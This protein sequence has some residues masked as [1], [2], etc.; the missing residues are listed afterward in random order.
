M[1]FSQKF[2]EQLLK[3]QRAVYSIWRPVSGQVGDAPLA[4]CDYATIDEKDLVPT[5]RP[6]NG[7]VAREIYNLRYNPKQKW[8]WVRDQ[9]PDEASL[10]VS[11]DSHPVEGGAECKSNI[12]RITLNIGFICI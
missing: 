5:D 8:Y 6:W 11:W 7:I 10:F 4:F 3:K 1:S 9:V 12:C 2:D